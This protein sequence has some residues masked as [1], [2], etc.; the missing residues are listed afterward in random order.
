MLLNAAHLSKV[1]TDRPILIDEEFNVEEGEKVGLIGVNG[2]GKSTLLRILAK[3]EEA[4]GLIQTKKGLQTALLGQNPRFHEDTVWKQLKYANAQNRFPKEDYEIR[5]VLTRLELD[6]NAVISE[7]SGG[8]Q[9]RVSLA[10]VLISDA[11][12]LFLDEPTNHLDNDMV[13]WL[14]DYINRPGRSFV[15]VTHDRW[16]LERVCS[17]IV[18]LDRGHLYEHKGNYET[19][20][21][22]KEQREIQEQ[23]RQQKHKNLY[24]QELEWV[25]AGCQARSTKQ[26][27]RLERFEQLRQVRFQRQEKAL[28]LALPSVRLGKKTIEWK[29]LAIGYGE[30]PLFSG[31]SY[32]LKRHDRIGLVGPNGC[33]KTTFLK[34]LAGDLKPDQGVIEQGSTVRIGFFRQDHE[35]E[36]LSQKVLDYIEEKAKVVQTSEGPVTASAM[37]ERFH[38]P[39]DMF[40]MPI[41]RLSGG[42]RR[43]LYLLR[44]LMEQ[45]NVL[46]LDE[47]TNDLDLITLEVLEDYLD[48][49]AGIVITVSHDRYF[50]DR[51][52]DYLFVWHPNHTFRQYTGGYSELLLHRKDGQKSAGSPTPSQKGS[53]PRCSRPSMSSREKKELETLPS[54]METLQNQISDLE[55]AMGQES[56]YRKIESLSIQRDKLQERLDESEM[57]WLELEEKREEM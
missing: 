44:V 37:L 10:C 35:I 36:D 42:E 25:R 32:Q 34:V 21:E 33:G 47:P 41:E 29:D 38:F 57:R 28:D 11:D 1:W 55:K 48:D 9:R 39:R 49:F 23:I 14:E 15:V 27:S 5:S 4:D 26:K 52:C 6:E 12:L 8:M 20:L 16:F 19:Y 31:F 18:E 54:L 40:Y 43:R 13:E 46:L 51:I 3:E 17:R 7:L 45:P 30:E 50:L 53:K 56:D 22:D 2:C 24:R